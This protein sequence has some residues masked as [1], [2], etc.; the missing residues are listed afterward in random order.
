MGMLLRLSG[1]IPKTQTANNAEQMTRAKRTA[2]L[3]ESRCHGA[4]GNLTQPRISEGALCAGYKQVA[5]SC[6]TRDRVPAPPLTGCLAL[7]K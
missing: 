5:E 6:Q 4:L 2:L 3:A 1:G 7:N